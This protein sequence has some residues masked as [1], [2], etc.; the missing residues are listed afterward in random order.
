MGE[1]AGFATGGFPAATPDPAHGAILRDS[2]GEPAGILEE[3]EATQLVYRVIGRRDPV[4][5][6]LLVQRI[7]GELQR[8]GIT[9]IHDIEIHD[10][11][12]R[13]SLQLFQ[14]LR[15]EGKLGVRVQMILPRN[16]LPELR[17][18]GLGAGFWG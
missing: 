7:L 16:M 17:A 2:A 6:R 12:G 3:Q 1:R 4:L 13:T 11:E 8:S 18:L 15:D 14:A 5:T 10:I 9:T